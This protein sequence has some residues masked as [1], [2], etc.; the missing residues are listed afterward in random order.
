MERTST[1]FPVTLDL[2][3]QWGEMDFYRHVN[4]AVYFRWFESARMAY[5]RRIGWDVV[6]AESGVGPILHSTT[7]RFRAPLE[8]PDSVRVATG[9][10][11]LAVDRFTMLY[12]VE[13]A[14]LARV[15]AEGS[16]VIVSFDYRSNAKAP[17]PEAVRAAIEALEAPEGEA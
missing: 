14:T 16:G 17:L 3:V 12:R 11:E 8:Y 5:F 13:S 9:V 10:V 15:A 6:E 7:A 4:N 1:R 2:P